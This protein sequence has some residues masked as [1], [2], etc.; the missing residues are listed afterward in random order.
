M[1]THHFQCECDIANAPSQWGGVVLRVAAPGH[2]DDP[3]ADERWR[4]PDDA[5]RVRCANRPSFVEGSLT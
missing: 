3:D 1:H 4:K 5:Q 2:A